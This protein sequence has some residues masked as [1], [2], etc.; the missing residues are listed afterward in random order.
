VT[1]ATA[2]R[3]PWSA[4]ETGL[5]VLALV[6]P[7]FLLATV[8]RLG[9]DTPYMDQWE[10]APLFAKWHDGTLSFGDLWAQQNES[11][12]VV[13][14]LLFLGLGLLTGWNLVAE[15]LPALLLAAF[16][17]WAIFALDR[18]ALG[19]SRA[20]ALGRLAFANLLLFGPIQYENWLW[21]HQAALFL[22]PACLLAG[23]LVVQSRLGLPAK[24]ALAALLG[25]VATFSFANGMILWPLLA[26]AL[27]VTSPG[28]PRVR[29]RRAALWAAGTIAVV[30]LYF[31][32]Y[33][34]PAAQPWLL[35]TLRHP[36]RAANYLAVLLGSPL[37]QGIGPTG[38]EAATALG[39][40][41]MLLGLAVFE[42]GR[43]RFSDPEQRARVLPW[44]L[45]VGFA[46]GTAMVTT[47]GRSGFDVPHAL[48]PRYATVSALFWVA[49]AYTTAAVL[50]GAVRGR[51]LGLTE[52]RAAA[53]VAV[54]AATAAACHLLATQ[55]ALVRMEN[56]RVR[57]LEARACLAFIDVAP[58]EPFLEVN[59]YP[60][61]GRLRERAAAVDRL[62][63]LRPS[64]VRP[65]ALAA[66]LGATPDPSF[67][68]F[69]AFAPSGDAI[70]C[71]GTAEIPGRGEAPDAI[72]LGWLDEGGARGVAAV[73]QAGKKPLGDRAHPSADFQRTT[74][75]ECRVPLGAVPPTVRTLRAWAYDTGTG[76]ATLL[77]GTATIPGR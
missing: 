25:L 66:L 53:A 31:A 75:W 42:I 23:L 41:G 6:P 12:M 36:G 50:P 55:V 47:V 44:L 58:N 51:V 18:R 61:V 27:L 32:G 17:S 20:A 46:Y 48:S 39:A 14:R 19:G 74:E 63:L 26:A 43:R 11:R 30:A 7:A 4:G 71:R 24:S 34:R 73:A 56:W 70:R 37:A 65:G 3:K 33:E 21:G 69:Q 35:E 5:L 40:A 59:C 68:K 38:I 28:E 52:T 8:L 2:E 76:R 64:I 1:G 57:R 10:V 15:L 49:L 22:P 45:L 9:V 60:D 77:P 54:L 16:E 62:G 29:L 72:L 67:G 13:P